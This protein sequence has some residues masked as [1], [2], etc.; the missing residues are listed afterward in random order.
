[1]ASNV[2]YVCSLIYNK[3]NIIVIL[4]YKINNN[5]NNKENV[6][7]YTWLRYI[8]ICIH[9]LRGWECRTNIF[10]FVRR[11]EAQRQQQIANTHSCYYYYFHDMRAC[12]WTGVSIRGYGVCV[13]LWTTEH[14]ILRWRWQ[15]KTFSFTIRFEMD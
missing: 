15:C 1:M 3:N 2:F 8:Y 7:N 4:L 14:M 5:N 6:E 13:C 10:A 11:D 12:V 9:T